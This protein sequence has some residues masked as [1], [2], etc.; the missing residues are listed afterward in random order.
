[1]GRWPVHNGGVIES[2]GKEKEE[3]GKIKSQNLRF[4][5]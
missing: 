4:Q 1:V 2:D 3:R 5:I